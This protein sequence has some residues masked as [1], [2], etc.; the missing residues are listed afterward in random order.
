MENQY[1]DY[2]ESEKNWE[3]ID[4]SK[5]TFNFAN[6]VREGNLYRDNMGFDELWVITKIH[7]DKIYLV[8][9]T[10]QWRPTLVTDYEEDFLCCFAAM[11]IVNVKVL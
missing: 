1:E 11:S 3:V 5:D 7:K 4:I 9:I 8:S 6:T 2:I 10:N